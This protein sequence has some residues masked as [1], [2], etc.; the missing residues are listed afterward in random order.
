MT[1][2]GYGRVPG[3]RSAPGC[4]ASDTTFQANPPPLDWDGIFVAQTK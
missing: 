3:A 4:P 2:I 1:D